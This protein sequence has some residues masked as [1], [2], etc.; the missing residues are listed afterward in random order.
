MIE[1]TRRVAVMATFALSAAATALACTND[2]GALFSAAAEDASQPTGDSAAVD[3]AIV[4]ASTIEGGPSSCTPRS[5]VLANVFLAPSAGARH[6]VDPLGDDTGPG[7]A[8]KPWRT[9]QRAVDV[10]APGETALVHGG[11]YPDFVV[12]TRA[13]TASAPI[14]LQGDLKSPA[15]FTDTFQ[16]KGQF[17]R[18]SGLVFDGTIRTGTVYPLLAVRAADVEVSGNEFRAAKGIA[19]EG[20]VEGT[21]QPSRG[22]VF[23]NWFHDGA[24]GIVWHSG[25]GT[26]IAGNL[27][28]DHTDASIVL[29]PTPQETFVLS[30]TIARGRVGVVLGINGSSFTRS[31]SVINN[32]ITNQK[33]QG[34]FAGNTNAGLARRNFFN[35]N[36]APTSAS[37]T[38][39]ENVL[40]TDPLYVAARDLHLQPTS[41]ALGVADLAFTPPVDRDGRCRPI[42]DPDVGA[43]E[44]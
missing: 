23:G 43:Y 18:V 7:T 27:F 40:G 28:H 14:T 36:T 24:Q 32:I 1:S 42:G 15:I 17:T 29:D 30:N 10:L 11:T 44:Q 38:Q 19:L 3:A 34:V 6:H 12:W 37:I 20:F 25:I 26:I 22:R 8:E 35:A 13:G 33:E 16:L 41:Q 39:S 2:F 4:E 5:G 21:T 31:T 9:V